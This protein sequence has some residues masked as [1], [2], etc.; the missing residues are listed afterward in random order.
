M[1]FSVLYTLRTLSRAMHMVGD[2]GKVTDKFAETLYIGTALI[3]LVLY[4]VVLSV[5]IFPLVFYRL[6]NELK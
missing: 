1:S 3:T 5:N 6:T 4:L 2:H